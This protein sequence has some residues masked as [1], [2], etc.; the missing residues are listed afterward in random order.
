MKRIVNLL[1]F[2]FCVFVRIKKICF[3]YENDIHLQRLKNRFF[4]VIILNINHL[5]TF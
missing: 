2:V 4:I 5:Y 1:L 3:L